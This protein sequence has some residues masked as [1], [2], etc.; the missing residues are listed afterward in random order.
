MNDAQQSTGSQDGLAEHSRASLQ[1]RRWR[2]L[3]FSTWLVAATALAILTLLVV[4]GGVNNHDAFTAAPLFYEHG[5]PFVFLDRYTPPFE[6]PAGPNGLALARHA[7][8]ADPELRQFLRTRET[9]KGSAELEPAAHLESQKTDSCTSGPPGWM[10]SIGR[11][12]AKNTLS[13]GSVWRWTLRWPS[14]SWRLSRL[15]V[16]GGPAG[17]GDICYGAF[18]GRAFLSPRRWPGGGFR[19]SKATENHAPSRPCATRG[20]RSTGVAMRQFGSTSSSGR[21][22][23][24]PS[25]KSALSEKQLCHTASLTNCRTKAAIFPAAPRQRVSDR[26]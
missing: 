23:C 24:V 9:K 5:W 19:L 3:H 4:P 13:H 2:R 12:G 8:H 25:T 14:Q 6:I 22:I 26:N 16:N 15:P 18:S 20:S 10:K 1:C 17:V 21:I 11:F 7:R